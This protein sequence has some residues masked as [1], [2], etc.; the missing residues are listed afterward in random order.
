MIFTNCPESMAHGKL[1][2]AEKPFFL[3]GIPSEPAFLLPY[4]CLSPH[5]RE[6][7]CGMTLSLCPSVPRRSDLSL[8]HAV[9]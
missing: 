4:P 5:S 2:K 1:T 6:D 3:K 9:D 7:G 8:R